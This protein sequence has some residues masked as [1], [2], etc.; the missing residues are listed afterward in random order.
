MWRLAPSLHRQS[1]TV[2]YAALLHSNIKL[3]WLGVFYIDSNKLSHTP[4]QPQAGGAK[5]AGWTNWNHGKPSQPNQ[6]LWET[7]ANVWK[8][9]ISHAA[10]AERSPTLDWIICAGHKWTKGHCTVLNFTTI[11]CPTQLFPRLVASWWFS[12]VL[13]AWLYCRRCNF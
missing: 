2:A 4:S 9:K 6:D 10:M 12:N 8:A 13:S 3:P 5:H 11:Y 7:F 1:E